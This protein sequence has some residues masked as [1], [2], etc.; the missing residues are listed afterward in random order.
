MMITPPEDI[1]SW[2]ISQLDQ[3]SVTE[4]QFSLLPGK[5]S[6][7][8]YWRVR[9][10][11]GGVVVMAYDRERRENVLYASLGQFLRSIAIP[12]PQILAHDEGKG[13]VMLEDLGDRD[14]WSYRGQPWEERALLYQRT[15]E[16]IYKLHAYPVEDPALQA[17]PLMEGFDD[18]L[19]RWERDYF[20]E[21][22]V[23]ELGNYHLSP[24]EG[25]ALEKELAALAKH[26][27][28]VPRRLIHRDFQSQNVMIRGGQPYLIDFQGMRL[29]NPLYDLASL[30]YDPYV[31]LSPEERM[32]LAHY[33]YAL[34]FSPLRLGGLLHPFVGNGSSTAHAG[35]GGLWLPSLKEGA[36]GVSPVCTPG[37]R[38][39]HRRDRLCP[40]L[41]ASTHTDLTPR[42][43]HGLDR[44]RGGRYK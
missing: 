16:T 6:G 35:L 14:L 38:I 12:V 22:F 33:Y 11:G 20:R 21:F 28:E 10:Q 31:S 3:A 30:L 25:W 44:G 27:L 13:F 2:T 41:A 42:V 5:G 17:L 8:Q 43:S 29:G 24:D 23:G 18:A 40:Y 32:Y 4:I 1:V 7:R 9:W 36:S 37:L 15:L 39:P 19:Y 34:F 26:L